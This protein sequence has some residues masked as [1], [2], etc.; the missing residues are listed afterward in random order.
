MSKF[1]DDPP[2]PPQVVK[3]H[4]FFFS[5][6]SFPWKEISMIFFLSAVVMFKR[7]L[8]NFK[9]PESL[10]SVSIHS[11]HKSIMVNFTQCQ[12]PFH[13]ISHPAQTTSQKSE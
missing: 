12:D 13:H 1:W 5:N 4:N 2:P 9:N 8:V 11:K 7:L 3:I 10:L 6:E